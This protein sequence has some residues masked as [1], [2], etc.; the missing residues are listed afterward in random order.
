M[1]AGI[2]ALAL[3]TIPP[4]PRGYVLDNPPVAKNPFNKFDAYTLVVA[5]NGQTVTRFDYPTAYACQHARAEVLKQI[6]TP[7]RDKRV[8]SPVLV[9]CVPR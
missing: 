8:S 9:F 5:S 7:I 6:A 4:P 1:I 2:V 3:Q